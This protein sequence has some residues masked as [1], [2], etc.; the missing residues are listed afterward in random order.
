MIRHDKQVFKVNSDTF[1]KSKIYF[2]NFSSQH[3]SVAVINF[4][5]FCLISVSTLAA[6]N[7]KNKQQQKQEQYNRRRHQY[8]VFGHTRFEWIQLIATLTVPMAL[9]IFTILNSFQ[10]INQSKNQFDLQ[11]RIAAENRQ[12]DLDIAAENRKKDLKIAEVQVR[13]AKDNRLKDLHIAAE[14]RRKDLRIAAENREKDLKIA[15]LQIHLAKDNRQNDIRIANETRLKDLHIAAENRGKDIEIA[16]ENRRKDLTIAEVQINIAEENRANAVRL[17]NETR[18][19]DLLIAAENRRKDIEIAEDNRQ[20][21]I[22]IGNETRQNDLL[23]A[24]ENRRKDIE[25]AEENR[26]KDFKIA[27]ENRRKDREVAED[28]QHHSIITEYQTFLSELI[29]K[30][31][32]QLNNTNYEAARFVARFK[33]L[34]AFR[35]LDPER[36]SLLLKSLYEGKLAGR[37]DEDMVIDLSSADLTNI[38]F[39]SPRD[40]IV[41]T[42]P[43]LHPYYSMNLSHTNLK[44]ASFN[45]V[46]FF[47]VSFDQAMMDDVVML[48][49]LT[50]L[51]SFSG[52]SLVRTKFLYS[53]HISV[54]FSEAQLTQAHFEHY[55][56]DR[57]SFNSSSLIGTRIQNSKFVRSAFVN[58]EMDS[59]VISQSEFSSN[60]NMMNVSLT[61]SKIHNSTFT[62]VD[63]RWCTIHE[64][65][66]LDS[67]FIKVNLYECKGLTDEQL[68]QAKIVSESILPNGTLYSSS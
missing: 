1:Q 58:A 22:R 12:K 37:L 19:N 8:V 65:S 18:S 38:D 27:E 10:Q 7:K 33:T 44:N 2:I 6:V 20:N 29:L 47:N 56:C 41:L 43:S 23:I 60:V 14:N 64:S 52:T 49:T 5:F 15:E 40:Q 36:K 31:G 24:S 13:I 55:E 59:S 9:G 21:D 30:E 26:R 48:S 57:C 25:I 61:K 46:S 28:Q 66:L 67:I 11:L 63:M 39:A 32:V 34:I 3:F 35:Q 16:A 53:H 42:L 45:S 54:D 17:A 51:I 68:R 4:I 50:T 62:D